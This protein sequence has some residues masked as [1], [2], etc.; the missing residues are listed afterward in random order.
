[1]NTGLIPRDFSTLL[2][3]HRTLLYQIM[4]FN[5]HTLLAKT[6]D[7]SHPSSH[8]PTL[9]ILSKSYSC[10]CSGKS[11]N[12]EGGVL[13]FFGDLEQVSEPPFPHLLKGTKY[14]RHR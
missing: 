14:L 5:D 7:L 4:K 12:F 9:D 8:A 3:L 1:M 6:S 11:L 10:V 2:C 13:C